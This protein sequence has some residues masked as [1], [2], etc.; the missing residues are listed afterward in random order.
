MKITLTKAAL[1]AEACCAR[2]RHRSLWLTVREVRLD[3]L[4]ITQC[5]NSLPGWSWSREQGG[6]VGEKGKKNQSLF[7]CLWEVALLVQFYKML[8][9][10]RF[11]G[12]RYPNRSHSWRNHLAASTGSSLNFSLEVSSFSSHQSSCRWQQRPGSGWRCFPGCPSALTLFPALLC[13]AELKVS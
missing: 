11:M 5:G 1:S 13:Q 8:T 4:S 6:D 12:K 7:L 3:D 10:S 2:R 9:L